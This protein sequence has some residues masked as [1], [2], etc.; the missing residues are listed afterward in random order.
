LFDEDAVGGDEPKK[1]CQMAMA[2]VA[3]W[4]SE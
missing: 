4:K 3:I 2:F 1:E